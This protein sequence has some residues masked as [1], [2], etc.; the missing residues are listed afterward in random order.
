MYRTLVLV[1][2][3]TLLAVTMVSASDHDIALNEIMYDPAGS[4]YYD[5]F[6][7]IYNTSQTDTTNLTGWLISDSTGT[8]SIIAAPGGGLLLRPLQFGLILDSGYFDNSTTYNPLPPEALILTVP[9]ASL[10]SGGLSNSVAEPIILISTAGD[11]V[12]H[13]RYSLGNK[14]GYSDEKIDPLAGDDFSNWGTS[15]NQNGTPGRW[16]S[17]AQR[18]HDLAVS[19]GDLYWSPL[20]PSANT[21]VML[22]VM[23]HN[24]GRLTASGGSVWFFHDSDGDSV[25]DPAEEIGSPQ[26]VPTLEPGASGTVAVAWVPAHEGMYSIGT[27][28]VWGRDEDTSNNRICTSITVGSSPLVI[29][30]IMYAPREG[31]PEWV[32]IYNRSG[33]PLD[34]AG[35]TIGDSDTSSRAVIA[36]SPTEILPGG[37]AVVSDD[38]TKPLVSCPLLRPRGGLPSLNN[39]EDAVVLGDGSGKVMDAVSY[40]GSWGGGSGTS[41]ERINPRLGSGDSLN[42]ASCTEPGGHTAG[43]WNSIYCEQVPSKG[44]LSASPNPFSPD[45]DGLNDRTLISYRLP[46]KVALVRLY[47]YDVHGRLLRHLLE[48]A[49]SGSEATTVW[50]GMDDN[51][52]PLS[53]G[54]YILYLEAVDSH[55]QRVTQA[56]ST[57]V[58]AKRL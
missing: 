40:R 26:E 18:G 39:D 10:G 46:A 45:G 8:D 5:E 48:Q 1:L 19:T 25:L 50:D 44:S 53:I 30:E 24:R 22:S 52:Q 11:T 38:A 43:R 3:C 13:Y 7:E 31:E 15:L 35:L 54:I 16:N 27:E 41:L 51:G 58:L 36:T 37:Y 33:Y 20:H 49:P 17:L 12:S 42:W 29:N 32:E 47:V 55:S 23:V 34:L 28:I 4:E 6:I 9:D 14:A 21:Q 57:V 56:K 2:S